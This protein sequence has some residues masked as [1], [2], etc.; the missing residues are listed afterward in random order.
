MNIELV[1]S[2][3]RNPV[4]P[5]VLHEPSGCFRVIRPVS[6]DEIIAMAKQLVQLQVER[7]ASL[8][9][10]D[11]CRAFLTLELGALEREV[12]YCIYLDNQHRVILGEV[13]FLGTIDS[14]TV[15]PRE[16]VKQALSLNA[17]AVIVAHNH[18]SGMLKPS[19][20]DIQLTRKLKEALA[21]IEVRVLD[22]FIVGGGSLCSFAE[23]GLL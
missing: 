14:A 22:H 6:S 20:A 2:D 18:P 1:G 8:D 9:S 11:A 23:E 17:C 12:F 19:E 7:G 21:L 10:P 13:C 15:H 3:D 5:F 4:T 16:L